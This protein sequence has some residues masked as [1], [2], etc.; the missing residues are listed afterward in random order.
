VSSKKLFSV[1]GWTPI[2]P[3]PSIMIERSA[4][5]HNGLCIKGML[6]DSI[7]LWHNFDYNK[8]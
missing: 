2:K 6:V 3:P 7:F 8:I 1:G 4:W 5:I